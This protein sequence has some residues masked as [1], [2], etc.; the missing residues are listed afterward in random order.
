MFPPIPSSWPPLEA[1]IQKNTGV[2]SYDWIA[3]SS[4]AMTVERKFANVF[5]ASSAS[6]NIRVIKFRKGEGFSGIVHN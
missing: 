1:A 5:M 6:G 4:P 2:S 3:G